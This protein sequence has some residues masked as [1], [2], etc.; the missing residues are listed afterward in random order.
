[1]PRPRKE[2]EEELY[3]KYLETK[4]NRGKSSFEGDGLDDLL[5]FADSLGYSQP[6]VR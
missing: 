3:I 4:L 5:D 1:M 2:E 6:Q